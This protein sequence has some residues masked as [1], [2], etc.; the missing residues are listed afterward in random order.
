[1][2]FFLLCNYSVYLLIVLVYINVDEKGTIML[3]GAGETQSNGKD[4]P[5]AG[6]VDYF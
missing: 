3:Q 4:T 5:G 1:M 2:G 6:C